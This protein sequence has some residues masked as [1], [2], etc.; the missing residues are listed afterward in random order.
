[1]GK[2]K[3]KEI[4]SALNISTAAVSMALNNKPGVSDETRQKVLAYYAQHSDSSSLSGIV[5]VQKTLIL[6]IYKE[7]GDIIIDKPFF[8]EIM[9]VSKKSI[10]RNQDH[11]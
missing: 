3:N 5:P 1:M 4:A 7:S 9:S 8:S 10:L 6:D 11:F 2:L